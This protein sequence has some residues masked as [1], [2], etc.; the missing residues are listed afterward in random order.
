VPA[1]NLE[2]GISRAEAESVIRATGLQLIELS[3]AAGAVR[4]ARS[5][6]RITQSRKVFIPRTRLCR[7]RCGYCTFAREPGDS[8]AHTM[9][10]HEVLAV[11]RIGKKWI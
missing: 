2:T 7:D 5:G 6:R 9:S 8:K 11:A 3:R 4:D 1:L 10:P